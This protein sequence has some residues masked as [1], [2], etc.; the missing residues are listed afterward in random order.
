MIKNY[1]ERMEESIMNTILNQEKGCVYVIP[2]GGGKTYTGILKI[3]KNLSNHNKKIINVILNPFDVLRGRIKYDLNKLGINTYNK[4][5]FCSTEITSNLIIVNDLWQAFITDNGYK[6]GGDNPSFLEKINKLKE[7]GYS[8]IF[9][10]DETHIFS[11]L[12]VKKAPKA[13]EFINDID[14]TTQIH[15]SA[16]PGN[17]FD[18]G[19]NKFVVTA[20]EVVNLG[21]VKRQ[22]VVNENESPY[23]RIE[24]SLDEYERI[25]ETYKKL[26]VKVLPKY[27][28]VLPQKDK[29]SDT[30]NELLKYFQNQ[31]IKRNFDSNSIYHLDTHGKNFNEELI[32]DMS[33]LDTEESKIRFLITIRSGLTGLSVHSLEVGCVIPNL[34]ETYQ[35]QLTGRFVRNLNEITHEI[36]P[37]I[38]VSHTQSFTCFGGY[39]K[40]IKNIR[41]FL[42]QDIKTSFP[43]G[44]VSNEYIDVINILDCFKKNLSNISLTQGGYE[45]YNGS[46]I[47]E[48][49]K[50][51][52]SGDSINPYG[53]KIVSELDKHTYKSKIQD[54]LSSYDISDSEKYE[55]NK[56]I[57]THFNFSTHEEMFKIFSQYK[58]LSELRRI[59]DIC[60][61]QVSNKKELKQEISY[62][63]IKLP[64]QLNVPSGKCPS[65]NDDGIYS[66]YLQF[67]EEGEMR[68]YMLLCKKGYKIFRNHGLIKIPYLMDNKYYTYEPDF[69]G[70][71][72]ENE[73]SVFD[74][75]GK[76]VPEEQKKSIPSKA[77]A[78]EKMGYLHYIVTEDF[79]SQKNNVYL[80]NKSD[81]FKSYNESPSDWSTIKSI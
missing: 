33:A 6:V 23:K 61:N 63:L 80:W 39:D 51:T 30:Y 21:F 48:Y 60:K 20:E 58:N 44:R 47:I 27:M 78:A 13:K 10:I 77:E 14:P 34:N 3:C 45:D 64:N 73:L 37:V 76:T 31:I 4:N 7:N 69:V 50:L 52:Q 70:F 25:C 19:L 1:L 32:T 62:I 68:C 54:A 57:K 26:G 5:E 56:T 74:R 81:K 75:K 53:Y 12:E 71:N 11:T 36:Y 18:F 65:F 24:D 42:K 16:T 29:K 28:L 43:S 66:G 38:F 9:T 59:L 22:I 67:D 55:F 2:T 72:I 40:Q 49:T 8:V 35:I 79:S 15:F 17:V 41:Y 46:E